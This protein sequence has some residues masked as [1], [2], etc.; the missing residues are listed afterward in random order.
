MRSFDDVCRLQAIS[1]SIFQTEQ[2]KD[3]EAHTFSATP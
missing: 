1:Q 2:T 3:L